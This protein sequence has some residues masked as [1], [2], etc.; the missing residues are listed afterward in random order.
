[1][2]NANLITCIVT[3]DV[4]QDVNNFLIRC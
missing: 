2:Q 4:M 1:M 3:G